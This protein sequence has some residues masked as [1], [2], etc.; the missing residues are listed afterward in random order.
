MDGFLGIFCDGLQAI[1]LGRLYSPLITN[2][3]GIFTDY[4]RSAALGVYAKVLQTIWTE[5]LEPSNY[6]SPGQTVANTRLFDCENDQ[7]ECQEQLSGFSWMYQ[8]CSEFGGPALPP[9]YPPAAC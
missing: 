9:T 1:A 6:P 7:A 4:K 2:S 5:V 8:V 3:A